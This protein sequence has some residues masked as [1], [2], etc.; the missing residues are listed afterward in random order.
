MTS[1]P[2]SLIGRS[3]LPDVR[4]RV[5]GDPDPGRS[6]L[7]DKF[8]VG[9]HVSLG[10]DEA[11]AG[12]NDSSL[13]PQPRNLLGADRP[14]EPREDVDRRDRGLLDLLI[15]ENRRRRG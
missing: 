1:A 10:P 9:Q 13:R 5:E 15:V 11:S 12:P 2:G 7:P 4:R 14:D 6:E 3:P 8:T